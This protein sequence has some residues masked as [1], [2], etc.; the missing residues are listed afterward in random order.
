MALSSTGIFAG[1]FGA[2]AGLLVCSTALFIS[3]RSRAVSAKRSR[4]RARAR[5]E[6]AEFAARSRHYRTAV[7]EFTAA[8]RLE[9]SS[10]RA[11]KG[12]GKAY[13]SLS[14]A[15]DALADFDR[16]ASLSRN[17]ADAQYHRA[18]ACC[19]LR[20]YDQ[21]RAAL[22]IALHI[23]PDH[24]AARRLLCVS[25]GNMRPDL[26]FGVKRTA[27]IKLSPD[28]VIA[29]IF[30]PLPPRPAASRRA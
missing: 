23:D 15:R 12:R 5:C 11:L 10:A 7:S 1:A 14:Q 2:L 19:A 26:L 4:R 25:E 18:R 6:R 9:P 27:E 24:A 21:A 8:M 3:R 13:L 29:T 22:Q 20:R 30:Q 28:T 16:W 17:A